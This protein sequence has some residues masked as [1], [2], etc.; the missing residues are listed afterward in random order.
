MPQLSRKP[1]GVADVTAVA[2]AGEPVSLTSVVE[3]DLA[4]S[5][6]LLEAARAE[7]MTLPSTAR[8]PAAHLS[9]E[10][11]RAAVFARLVGISRG[12]SGTDPALAHEIVSALNRGI[13]LPV[14]V[15]SAAIGVGALVVDQLARLVNASDFAVALSV[16][17]LRATGAGGSAAPFSAQVQSAH[18]SVGQAASAA[19]IGSLLTDLDA[20]TTDPIA[21]RSAPQVNGAL[22]EAVTALA[23]AVTLELNSRA[24]DPLVDLDTGSVVRGGNSELVGLTLAFERV[25]LALAHVAAASEA[26]ASVVQSALVEAPVV[27]SVHVGGRENAVDPLGTLHLLQL[28]LTVTLDLLSD[29]A[30]VAAGVAQASVLSPPLAAYAEALA[31]SYAPDTLLAAANPV[32]SEEPTIEALDDE[33]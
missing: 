20:A 2:R 11:T 15:S 8:V 10:E 27:Y 16:S 22:A 25:R 13:S 7:G 28:S 5:Y 21:F 14:D 17:A 6:S 33:I 19:R 29:E 18:R 4:A 24:D 12:G 3:R 23:A 9:E 32:R 30:E 26:R 1:I 31:G